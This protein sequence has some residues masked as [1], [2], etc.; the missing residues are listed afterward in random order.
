[1]NLN[2]LKSAL[3]G[4]QPNSEVRIALPDGGYVPAH[5]HVTEVGHIQKDF[6]DCGGKRRAARTCTLQ[7]WMGSEQDDGHRL[8]VERFGRIL[9]LTAPLFADEALP[10]E[11]EYEEGLISQFPLDHVTEDG[12]RLVLQLGSKH[13]NCLARETCG[14]GSG[15][16]EGC[17]CGTVDRKSAT[18]C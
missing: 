8:T 14:V 5:F 13:T 10:V 6:I 12:G 1:M 9:A 2:E 4:A 7:T 15:D 18:C 16:Q 3:A 17:G 11:V